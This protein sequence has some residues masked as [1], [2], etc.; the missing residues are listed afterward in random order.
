MFLHRVPSQRTPVQRASATGRRLSAV[1]AAL[2]LLLLAG[3]GA[4]AGPNGGG[5]SASLSGTVS[6]AAGS[7]VLEGATV[8]SGTRQTT[9]DA[10]GRFEL[11]DLPVGT[12]TVRAERVG[13]LS[14][15]A[16]VTLRAGANTR[17]FALAVQEVFVNGAEAAYVPAGAGPLRSVII[18]LG[19]PNTR[20]FVT[21]E[22]IAPADNPD[23][24]QSLQQLGA[25][26]RALA[27]SSR[28]VLL[29]SST[30]AMPN[31]AGSDDALFAAIGSF[32][33]LS[34]HAE[35]ANAPVLLFG[36]SAGCPEASGLV[37]RNPQ[38]AIGVLVRVPTSV[39]DVTAPAALAV[40][41][42][43]MQAELDEVV[44][45]AAVRTTYAA[46]RSR[47]GLWALAIEP[48]VG[49]RVAT[50]RGNSTVTGWISMALALRVPATPGDPLVGLAEQ[51]GWLGNTSTLEIAAWADYVGDRTA[52]SW[53]LS[54]AAATAWQQ[55]ATGAGP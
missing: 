48:G 19:G 14:A 49:H 31:S 53:L 37:S 23:L 34:G 47:G 21:G 11:T 52:A 26:L 12:V 42:F 6:A 24:E 36:L 20:G 25:N 5:E 40:P 18:V 17:D 33:T 38:R 50:N 7:A 10:A 46:N 1:G 54:Q 39:T 35:L 16:T 30:I 45:N 41:T 29:G 51:S 32:A 44:D 28:A 3:C 4:S 15:E 22:R 55:L 9:S 2:A 8:T 13:Y 43:V 27:T